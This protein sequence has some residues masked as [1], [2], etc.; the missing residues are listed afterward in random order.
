MPL[1]V[2]MRVVWRY[3]LVGWLN[4][5]LEAVFCLTGL[6]AA[7]LGS[8]LLLSFSPGRRRRAQCC[9]LEDLTKEVSRRRR[10]VRHDVGHL[11]RYVVAAAN[12]RKKFGQR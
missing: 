3:A 7:A 12:V 9:R 6:G 4:P 10:R 5:E 8:E 1:E 2:D 11:R